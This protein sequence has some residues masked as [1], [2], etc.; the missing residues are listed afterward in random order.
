[1]LLARISFSH[2]KTQNVSSGGVRNQGVLG[3]GT[4]QAETSKQECKTT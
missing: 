2:L 3:P 4:S 1:M